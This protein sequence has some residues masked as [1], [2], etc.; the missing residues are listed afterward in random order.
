[1]YSYILVDRIPAFTSVEKSSTWINGVVNSLEEAQIY[2]D[3]KVKLY[4]EPQKMS[5]EDLIQRALTDNWELDYIHHYVEVYDGTQKISI[6]KF[7]TKNR[8]LE[9]QEKS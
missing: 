4:Q 1:M 6:F 7:N 2:Y 5:N 8:R 3:N 9:E